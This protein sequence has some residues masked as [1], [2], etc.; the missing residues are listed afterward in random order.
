MTFSN[1]F[2]KTNFEPMDQNNRPTITIRLKPYLQDFYFN[3]LNKEY[4]NAQTLFGQVIRPFIESR[5]SSIQYTPEHGPEFITFPLP[6]YNDFDVKKGVIWIS[7]ENQKSIQKIL[8]RHFKELFYNFMDDKVRFTKS[9][10][11]SILQFCYDY[12]VPFKH[13]YYESL[14][15]DYYRRRKS[16]D[17]NNLSRS[18]PAMRLKCACFFLI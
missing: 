15:K 2:L 11:K 16:E 12:N 1:N 7:P 9:F 13:E 10:K 4:V 18:V 5:P 3:V 17:K 6:L 14:K 8:E